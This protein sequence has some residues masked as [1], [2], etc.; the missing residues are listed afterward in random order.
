M[1]KA[2]KITITLDKATMTQLKRRCGISVPGSSSSDPSLTGRL[3][4]LATGLASIAN[5][6]KQIQAAIRK[7]V[8]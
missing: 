3:T 6:D 8:D 7:H 5:L 2:N 1:A 4:N